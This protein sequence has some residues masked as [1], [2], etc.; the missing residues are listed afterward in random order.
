MPTATKRLRCSSM[1]ALL[2]NRTSTDARRDLH[3]TTGM[4]VKRAAQKL[5]REGGNQKGDRHVY[6]EI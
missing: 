6:F 2:L 3:E 1:A 4:T 5:A